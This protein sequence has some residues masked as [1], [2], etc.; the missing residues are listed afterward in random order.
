MK[1]R[2]FIK[3]LGSTV[4][5]A[6][7]CITGCSVAAQEETSKATEQETTTTETT[8]DECDYCSSA[9]EDED[10]EMYYSSSF[11]ST[12]GELEGQM[13][14]MMPYP[15]DIDWD[16][17][18]EEWDIGDLNKIE[19][20]EIRAIAQS[21]QDDGYTIS[22]PELDIEFGTGFGDAEYMFFDGFNAY[23]DDGN[24]YSYYYVYRMNETLFNYYFV[25]WNCFEE[26]SITDDGTVIRYGE[27]D[28]YVEFNR[29][30]G[31][32]ILYCS[33]DSSQGMG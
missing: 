22:D 28:N 3:A 26:E 17:M 23:K 27:D 8:E 21:Y 15:D 10:D 33:F 5:T 24:T 12:N 19:D 16:S 4:L 18:P 2:K 7:L 1:N 13:D 9:I 20:E 32:G 11:Q 31:I 6:S 25:E 30:T 14:Y 29:D